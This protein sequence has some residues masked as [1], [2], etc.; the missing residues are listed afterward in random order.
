M[1]PLTDPEE[2]MS[3]KYRRFSADEKHGCILRERNCVAPS[4][5]S[6][7]RPSNFELAPSTSA[8]APII[9]SGNTNPQQFTKPLMTF[10]EVSCRDK[11]ASAS[12]RLWTLLRRKY[13]RSSRMMTLYFI[14]K[15]KRLCLGLTCHLNHRQTRLGLQVMRKWREVTASLAFSFEC[16]KRSTDRPYSLTHMEVKYLNE[17]VH[18]ETFSNH[19]AV[20][21][22]S[23]SDIYARAAERKHV[24]VERKRKRIENSKMCSADRLNIGYRECQ[25]KIHI[26]KLLLTR[27]LKMR[28]S[29]ITSKNLR[30]LRLLKSSF[31]GWS[32][33][34]SGKSLLQ[35]LVGERQRISFLTGVFNAWL[36]WKCSEILSSHHM[37]CLFYA[38]QVGCHISEARRFCIARLHSFRR[39]LRFWKRVAESD[40]LQMKRIATDRY[41]RTA[42]SCYWR[43]FVAGIQAAKIEKKVL[44][45]RSYLLTKINEWIETSDDCR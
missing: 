43:T 23:I 36:A 4:E 10:R 29:I 14:H 16:N 35:K 6:R 20:F 37:R 32:R 18:R 2:S 42:M 34:F 1:P 39:I 33:W 26:S 21:Q 24:L 8:I 27:K 41:N 5:Y 17:T 13:M 28:E 40:A 19:S 45:H 22:A 11:K 38:F 15:L 25:R 12:S 9:R 7:N 30:N 31:A 3:I 44:A